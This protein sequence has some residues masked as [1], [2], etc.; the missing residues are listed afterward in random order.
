LRNEKGRATGSDDLDTLGLSR[1]LGMA[2]RRKKGPDL[3]DFVQAIVVLVLLC[4]IVPQSR[5][6]AAANI[7][8]GVAWVI[9]C[10]LFVVVAVAIW[11]LFQRWGGLGQIGS[12]NEKGFDEWVA[13]VSP[14][15]GNGSRKHTNSKSVAE[16]VREIDWFQFEKLVALA[17]SGQGLVTRKGGANSDGGIDLVL[18]QQG[19][20]I[21]IQCK[22][23]K[24]WNVGVKVV[25]E[26]IGAMAD[27]RLKKGIIVS[28]KGCSGEAKALAA[29]HSIELVEESGLLGLLK[30]LNQAEVQAILADRRKVCPRCERGMVLRTA[31]KGT[32]QGGQFWG[33][34][35][36]P[37]C[38]QT[39][40]FEAP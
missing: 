14:A 35:G 29:R 5:S 4:A 10:V 27:A 20:R 31:R 33:C 17:Y 13:T 7:G 32:G 34:S 19:E 22:H 11:S 38:W 12:G 23:W 18:E 26:M 1:W 2:R 9:G 37:K 21:G 36:Y 15:V 6:A 16:Q 40:P 39:M 28:L 24:A 8:Q 30:Y 25:R 3:F